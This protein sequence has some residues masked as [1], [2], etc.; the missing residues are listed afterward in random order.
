MVAKVQQQS[1][2]GDCLSNTNDDGDDGDDA[3][4]DGILL[5]FVLLVLVLQVHESF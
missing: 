2:I 4:V 3:E 5:M 1:E